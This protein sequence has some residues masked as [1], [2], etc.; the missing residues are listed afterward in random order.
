[1]KFSQRVWLLLTIA[2]LSAFSVNNKAQAQATT[3]A[4]NCDFSKWVNPKPTMRYGI[5]G[6]DT[7]DTAVC[8]YLVTQTEERFRQTETIAYLRITQFQDEGFRQA[9]D[10]GVAAG[11]TVNSVKNGIYDFSL[12][13]LKNQRIEIDAADPANSLLSP[14]VEQKLIHSSAEQP[15]ALILSF[16][17]H[18]GSECVC[19][20]LADQIRLYESRDR[21]TAGSTNS[22]FDP[23]KIRVDDQV[24]GLEVVAMSEFLGFAAT[25]L[26]K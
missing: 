21:A 20:N 6:D 8:G 13:C 26:P 18:P 17:Q 19:C 7:F 4:K 16:T 12:G 10:R 15:I 2:T 25:M 23:A 11:N 14:P 24:F 3:P 1:M 5:F 9:I 22:V